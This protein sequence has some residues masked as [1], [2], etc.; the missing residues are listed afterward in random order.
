MYMVSTNHCHHLFWMNELDK[1]FLFSDSCLV[2]RISHVN[3]TTHSVL[4]CLIWKSQTTNK[5]LS[6]EKITIRGHTTQQAFNLV[7]PCDK[8]HIINKHKDIYK[9]E[10][11]ENLK[12]LFQIQSEKN[13]ED[14]TFVGYSGRWR[15]LYSEL[16]SW[17][18]ETFIRT[19]Q[20]FTFRFLPQRKHLADG[21]RAA[22]D[23]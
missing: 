10:S 4:D 1:Q 3:W 15:I 14:V 12:H 16:F 21:R 13:V 5:S 17:D 18:P 6:L 11:K 19:I 9:G 2:K 22:F 7:R 20:H 8:A 23:E